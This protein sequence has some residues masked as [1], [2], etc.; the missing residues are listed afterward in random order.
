MNRAS[1]VVVSALGVGLWLSCSS[2]PQGGEGQACYPNGTCN[3]GLTCLSKLCVNAGGQ[4][5]GTGTDAGGGQDSGSTDAGTDAGSIPTPPTLGAEIDRAGRPGI[6]IL[7]DDTFDSSPTTRT[8]DLDTY[9]QTASPAQW[10]TLESKITPALAYWDAL[11]ITCQNQLLSTSPASATSYQ[12]LGNLLVDDRLYLNTASTTCQ[13]YLGVELNALGVAINSDC[14]GW[15]P[16]EDAIDV[17]YS[18][19]I[20]GQPNTVGDGVN[21]DT[22]ATAST[23]VFPYLA[24][25]H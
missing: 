13:E 22:D 16:L 14:G 15:T 10:P 11:D 4:D 8:Q 5:S 25:P 3:A 19:L 17:T 12:T 2:S 1:W 7:L 6:N 24:P 20:T 21:S 9:N 23:T 18:F